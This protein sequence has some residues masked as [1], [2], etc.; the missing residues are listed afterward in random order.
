MKKTILILVFNVYLTAAIAQEY[1]QTD[2]VKS[3]EKSFYIQSYENYGA[4]W[5]S[6]NIMWK[7]PN[8]ENRPD[9]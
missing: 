8:P 7:L 1:I 6:D 9:I 2:T 5:G 3:F 4:L